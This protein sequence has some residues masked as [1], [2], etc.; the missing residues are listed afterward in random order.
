MRQLTRE[1][2][3][4][5]RQRLRECSA[6]AE[7]RLPDAVLDIRKS[8]GLTQEKF[9]ELTGMTKRQVAEIETGKGNPTFD[10]LNKIGKLFGFTL[11]FVPRAGSGPT[12]LS[13]REPEPETR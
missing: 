7:L 8:L 6:A 10:T 11:G 3:R 4:A 9:A 1:E 13:L 2:I 12:A 5:R